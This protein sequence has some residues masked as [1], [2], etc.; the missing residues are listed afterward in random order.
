MYIKYISIKIDNMLNRKRFKKF[1]IS[2]TTIKFDLIVPC[3]IKG[4]G[5]YNED[6]K[7]F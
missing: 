5:V 7:L 2:L 3:E 6:S 1:N 4:S